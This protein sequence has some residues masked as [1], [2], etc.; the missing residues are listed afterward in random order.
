V[1]RRVDD[2]EKRQCGDWNEYPGVATSQP[3]TTRKVPIIKV[4]RQDRRL[5]QK[6]EM[7]QSLRRKEMENAF[8]VAH[9]LA[10]ANY[11]ESRFPHKPRSSQ[12]KT[13]TL[14]TRCV[15]GLR[16]ESRARRYT[17]FVS[18]LPRAL[19]QETSSNSFQSVNGKV[20]DCKGVEGVVAP[21]AEQLCHMTA[22]PV[23]GH[24]AVPH[25]SL[26]S[27]RPGPHRAGSG[28]RHSAKTTPSGWLR[29]VPSNST[30]V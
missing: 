3:S 12:E 24:V 28:Y 5:A 6:Q 7:W 20:K 29:L 30:H 10:R 26:R 15:R 27:R 18:Q 21:L 13:S 22:P 17:L 9:E 23:F 1:G 25:I 8:V 19:A 16:R 14:L 11:L 4:C 2:G